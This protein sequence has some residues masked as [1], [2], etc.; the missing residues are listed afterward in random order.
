MVR[1][2]IRKQSGA[3][4][5]EVAREARVVMEKINQERDD[6]ELMMIIDQS[7]FIQNSI[8]NVQKCSLMGWITGYLYFISFPA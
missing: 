5:V 1:M 7:V 2:G 4:T 6:L 8:N 3:N